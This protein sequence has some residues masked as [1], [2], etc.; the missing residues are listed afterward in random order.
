MFW[1]F[2]KSVEQQILF[3]KK[4]FDFFSEV[5]VVESSPMNSRKTG[6]NNF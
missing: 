2:R 4:N 5:H 6:N 1:S 3:Q